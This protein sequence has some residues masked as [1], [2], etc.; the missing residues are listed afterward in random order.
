MQTGRQESL[1]NHRTHFRPFLSAARGL[2]GCLI[3]LVAWSARGADSPA[4]LSYT[5]VLKGSVPEYLAL[6]VSSNGD[7]TYEGRKL[8]EPS[9]PLVFKL[10]APTT[11]RLFEL[12][13]RLH[14]FQGIDLESHKK[15]ANLG[16]KTLTYERDGEKSQ[17]EFNYTQR[18][19]AQELATLFEKIASVQ[20]HIVGLE[21]AIKYDHLSLPGELRRIQIDLDNS[22]LADPQLLVPALEKIERNPR[23]LHLA[24]VRAQNILQRLQASDQ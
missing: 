4:K 11:Q 18:R 1:S 7:A 8:D 13:A 17:A 12:A 6:T 9:N 20:Q 5:K 23:F 2:A 21:R 10:S 14:N 15:V 3:F 22:A 19:D 24:R 16:L